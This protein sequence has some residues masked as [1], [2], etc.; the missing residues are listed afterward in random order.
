MYRG[1]IHVHCPEYR[2]VK[3]IFF[4]E[5]LEASAYFHYQFRHMAIVNFFK[6]LPLDLNAL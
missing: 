4:T 2:Y 5:A 3:V 6:I 1:E